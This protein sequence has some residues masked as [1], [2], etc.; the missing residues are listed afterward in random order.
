MVQFFGGGGG[1]RYLS[2]PQ[3]SSAHRSRPTVVTQ[4]VEW[5]YSAVELQSNAVAQPGI[6]AGG[7]HVSLS[8]PPLPSPPIPSPPLRSR[9]Q[10][11]LGV[12]GSAVSSPSGVWGGAPAEIDCGAFLALK[13][14]IWWQQF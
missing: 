4:V 5:S 6:Y 12:W 10:I 1:T 3:G 2:G 9:P 14:A 8:S 13:Y 11:Q 7:A